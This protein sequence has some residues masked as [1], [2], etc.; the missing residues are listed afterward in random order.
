L[1]FELASCIGSHLH[2]DG[3]DRYACDFAIHMLGQPNR[4]AS[5]AAADVE[6]SRAAR[7]ISALHDKLY[8]LLCRFNF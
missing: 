5:D 8:Q 1:L 4:G 7:K 6:N 3:T 2:L